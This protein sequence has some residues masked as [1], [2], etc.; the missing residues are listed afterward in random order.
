MIGEDEIKTGLI[1][2]K[3][4]SNGLQE[5]ITINDFIKKLN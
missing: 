1:S 3:D 2:V 5:N 4:M